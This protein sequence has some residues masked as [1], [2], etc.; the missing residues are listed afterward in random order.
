MVVHGLSARGWAEG[1]GMSESALNRA[2][3]RLRDGENPDVQLG[4]I[5][6]LAAFAKVTPEWLGF[7]KGVR[8]IDLKYPSR[9]GAMA[10]GEAQKLPSRAI[11]KVEAMDPGL[12]DPGHGFWWDHLQAEI[13]S[14][15]TERAKVSPRNKNR[16][17][18][19]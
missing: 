1:A 7:G 10:M 8:R 17:H 15:E 13:A 6:A 4:T 9:S 11:A 2:I 16:V 3:G 19:R 18:R 12:P 5:A 14:L